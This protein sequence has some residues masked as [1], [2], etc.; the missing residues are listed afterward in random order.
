M[1]GN[2]DPGR[3]RDS[4]WLRHTGS[5]GG[6]PRDHP[7]ERHAS[8]EQQQTT[9]HDQRHIEPSECEEATLLRLTGLAGD[10]A[11][12]R[13][14]F[15]NPGR[16]AITGRTARFD[17]TRYP[18]RLAAVAGTRRLGKRGRREGENSGNGRESDADPPH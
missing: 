18:A 16:S 7:A 8:S 15:G 17:L 3:D 2:K 9:A 4:R 6:V 14:T 11:A 12:A 1:P 13:G 5:L 10:S